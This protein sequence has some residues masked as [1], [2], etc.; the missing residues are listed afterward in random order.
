MNDKTYRFNVSHYTFSS[1]Q[2]NI[3]TKWHVCYRDA[4]RCVQT[5]RY[6]FSCISLQA[7]HI[8]L[9]MLYGNYVISKVLVKT[10]QLK[11]LSAEF[12]V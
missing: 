9:K 4:S 12:L 2:T 3:Y 7:I 6:H 1:V 8:S 10:L 5:N 11:F